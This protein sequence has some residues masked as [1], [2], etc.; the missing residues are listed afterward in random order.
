MIYEIVVSCIISKKYGGEEKI[1]I[2]ID[3]DYQFSIQRIIQIISFRAQKLI[4]ENQLKNSLSVRL[5][6][7]LFYII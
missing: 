5:L 4:E 2:V 7:L 6:F 1:S 3:V